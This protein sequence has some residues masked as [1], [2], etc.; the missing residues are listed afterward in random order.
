MD[1]ARAD[2]LRLQE[3]RDELDARERALKDER[4]KAAQEA[5]QWVRTFSRPLSPLDHSN[6]CIPSHPCPLPTLLDESAKAAQ[7][8]KEWIRAFPSL[9]RFESADSG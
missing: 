1:A 2:E 4:A 5:Q 9:F 6:R 3:T 7:E 8:A